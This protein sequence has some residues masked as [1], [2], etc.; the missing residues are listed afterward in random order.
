M[1]SLRMGGAVAT[2]R[3]TVSLPTDLVAKLK[4]EAGERSMSAFVAAL[5]QEHLEEAEL[6]RLW[7]AYVDDVGVTADDV[8][9]ADRV[10]NELL[11]DPATDAA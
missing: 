3:V 8:A 2:T 1:L 11:V 5:I 10:L 7:K 9:T 6:E 4:T